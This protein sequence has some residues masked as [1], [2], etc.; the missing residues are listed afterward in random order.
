M[1]YFNHKLPFCPNIGQVPLCQAIIQTSGKSFTKQLKGIPTAYTSPDTAN[2]TDREAIDISIDQ[3]ETESS[4]FQANSANKQ[5]PRSPSEATESSSLEN[6]LPIDSRRLLSVPRIALE[7]EQISET[8]NKE[9]HSLKQGQASDDVINSPSIN[10]P[11]IIYN[12]VTYCIN[13]RKPKKKTRKCFAANQFPATNLKLH[14]QI[15]KGKKIPKMDVQ[16]QMCNN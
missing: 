4:I 7:V 15:V 5:L 6:S 2:R 9:P 12:Q 8:S 10:S 13:Y 14:K 3:K 16:R 11:A 1:N